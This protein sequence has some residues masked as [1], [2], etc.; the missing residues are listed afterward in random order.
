MSD[1]LEIQALKAKYRKK[2]SLLRKEFSDNLSQDVF[3]VIAKKVI[4]TIKQNNIEKPVVVNPDMDS[5]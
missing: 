4:K 2:Q 5:K 1:S 3:N